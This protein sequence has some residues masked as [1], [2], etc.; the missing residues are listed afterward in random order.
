MT[1]PSE[2]K[3]LYEWI[4]NHGFYDGLNRIRYGCLQTKK[5]GL[6]IIMN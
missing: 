6:M 4:E 5:F 1:M 2:I 3:L